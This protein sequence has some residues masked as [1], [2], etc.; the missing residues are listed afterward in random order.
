VT[1]FQDLKIITSDNLCIDYNFNNPAHPYDIFK[2]RTLQGLTWRD[3]AS[4]ITGLSWSENGIKRKA[5][6]PSIQSL[7]LD[8]ASDLI[9]IGLHFSNTLYPHPNNGVAINPSGSIDHQIRTPRVVRKGIYTP[10]KGW[11]ESTNKI[12]E[13][14]FFKEKSETWIPVE[15]PDEGLIFQVEG[16]HQIETW[17][18]RTRI[19]LIFGYEWCEIRYYDPLNRKW[20][21]RAGIYRQ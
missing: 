11:I 17:E 19:H 7:T 1:R 4:H 13:E 9:L 3:P 14:I 10:G 5:F 18:G 15:I 12:N 21:E 2:E 6:F 20:L 16:I 8:P